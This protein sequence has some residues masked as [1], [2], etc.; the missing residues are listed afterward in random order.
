MGLFPTHVRTDDMSGGLWGGQ[1]RL[2]CVRQTHSVG[3]RNQEGVFVCSVC[4]NF[5]SVP[6]NF[7]CLFR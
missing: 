7:L 3:H 5:L 2:S 6:H 1:T 4:V